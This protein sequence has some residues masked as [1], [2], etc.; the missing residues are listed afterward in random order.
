[1]IIIRMN[2]DGRRDPVSPKQSVDPPDATD[3]NHDTYL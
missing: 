2:C 3:R 1:M